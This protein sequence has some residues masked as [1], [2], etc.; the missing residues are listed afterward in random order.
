MWHAVIIEVYRATGMTIDRHAGH[1]RLR[2]FLPSPPRWTSVSSPCCIVTRCVAGCPRHVLARGVAGH[3]FFPPA[4]LPTVLHTGSDLDRPAPRPRWAMPS[5]P[6]VR[7]AQGARWRRID[8]ER[9]AEGMPVV[10]LS[11]NASGQRRARPRTVTA[12]DSHLVAGGVQP[13]TPCRAAVWCPAAP[14]A[15][16]SL[17][18]DQSPIN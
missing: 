3:R 2:I 15:C 16:G 9:R 11:S 14:A 12:S 13:T 5:S 1:R 4:D 18:H 10:C 7:R 8:R 6:T 17:S